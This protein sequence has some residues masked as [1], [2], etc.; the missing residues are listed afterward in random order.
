MLRVSPFRIASKLWPWPSSNFPPVANV[1]T[2]LVAD[3]NLSSASRHAGRAVGDLLRIKINLLFLAQLCGFQRLTKA[4]F[5]GH[6]YTTAKKN[7]PRVGA[8]GNP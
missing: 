8:T 4:S 3:S 1:W 5:G 7:C 6:H 2:T